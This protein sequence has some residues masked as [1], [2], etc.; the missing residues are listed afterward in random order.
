MTSREAE[1]QPAEYLRLSASDA[2]RLAERLE[3]VQAA[4]AA[5][6]GRA[7]R[8]AED[9]TLVAVTK[10]VSPRLIYQAALLGLRDFGENYVQEAAP[11]R[12]ALASA[13]PSG[14]RWHLIG[15]LQANKVKAAL[16]LFDIIETVDSL[17]LAEAVSHRAG[18]RMVPVLLEVAFGHEAGRPGFREEELESAVAVMRDLPGLSIQG[19]MTVPPLEVSLGE[20]RRIFRRL[21]ELRERLATAY[22][23]LAWRH[24]S[25]GMTGDYEIAIEEGATIVRIGRAIFGERPTK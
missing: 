14:V 2:A 8:R 10:T 25:M 16:E 18:E 4:I 21:R 13:L 6:A 7:A 22:P 1:K 3:Q 9:V 15:H 12:A 19:L 17:R 20:T 5:A 24:L 11:K 23:D